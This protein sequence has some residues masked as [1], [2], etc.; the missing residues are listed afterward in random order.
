MF[1]QKVN[2]ELVAQYR[3]AFFTMW[4]LEETCCESKSLETAAGQNAAL[5]LRY[6]SRARDR[7][8]R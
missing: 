6:S 2:Q 4:L 7:A 3:C 5:K 1:S 8:P